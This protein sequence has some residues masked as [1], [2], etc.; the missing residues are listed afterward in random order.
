MEFNSIL[1]IVYDLYYVGESMSK[2]IMVLICAVFILGCTTRIIEIEKNITVEKIVYQNITTVIKEECNT[3][4]NDKWDISKS[5]ELDLI[6]RIRFLEGQQSKYW[7]HTECNYDLN[8][9]T[10]DLDDCE[11]ELCEWNSSWC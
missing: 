9:T 6:R 7:N 5:R 8:K 2:I 1:G 10:Q 3:T 11:E 4:F